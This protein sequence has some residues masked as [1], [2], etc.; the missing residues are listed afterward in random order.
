M[1]DGYPA[2][3]GSADIFYTET[4]DEGMDMGYGVFSYSFT[5]FSLEI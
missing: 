4:R 5:I 3:D 1:A 2:K